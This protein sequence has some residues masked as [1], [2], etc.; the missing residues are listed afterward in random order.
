MNR[1][2]VC[3]ISFILCITVNAQDLVINPDFVSE[4]HTVLFEETEG[5]LMKKEHF[6]MKSGAGFINNVH[7]IP[8]MIT[9]IRSGEKASYIILESIKDHCY[10]IIDFD[11]I[12]A[13]IEALNYII[14]SETSN[15]APTSEYV[16]IFFKTRDGLII[17]ASSETY[18]KKWRAFTSHTK[19]VDPPRYEHTIGNLQKIVSILQE[20]QSLLEEKLGY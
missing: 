15:K 12:P 14:E 7:I 1:F 6:K 19:Y 9:D 8:A 4:S 17:G 11:E 3:V 16:E 2:V 10:S 13:C 20:S 5:L 18:S